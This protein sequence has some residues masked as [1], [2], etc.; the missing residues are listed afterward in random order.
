[1]LSYM[2]EYRICG[3]PVLHLDD[4]LIGQLL[5][6]KSKKKVILSGVICRGYLGLGFFFFVFALGGCI[7]MSALM[8]N[9]R[10]SLFKG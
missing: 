7:A 8:S 9:F 3:Q 2:K 10:S 5:L 6:K 1:M 4:K